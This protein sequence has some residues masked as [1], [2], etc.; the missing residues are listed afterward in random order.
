MRFR[1][2][3]WSTRL[4]RDWMCSGYQALRTSLDVKI[5]Y[6]EISEIE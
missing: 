6:F 5:K 4:V 1:W 3:I 2:D